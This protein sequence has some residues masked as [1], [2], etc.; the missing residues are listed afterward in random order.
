VK[1]IEPQLSSH[2]SN[3]HPMPSVF[4]FHIHICSLDFRQFQATNFTG[5]TFGNS[6]LTKWLPKMAR[7]MLQM[8]VLQLFSGL[9]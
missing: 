9:D 1:G 5:T 8:D 6:P 4:L 3:I 2:P 7:Y